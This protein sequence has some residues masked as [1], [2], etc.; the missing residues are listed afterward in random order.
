MTMS[1]GLRFECH[2]LCISTTRQR[3]IQMIEG[4]LDRS[5]TAVLVDYKRYCTEE[6]N[7]F[8]CLH[9]TKSAIEETLHL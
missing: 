5:Q 9:F 3:D 7:T 8:T 4:H 2:D 1:I 6:C